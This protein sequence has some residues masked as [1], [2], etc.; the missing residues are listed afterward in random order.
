M[1]FLLPYLKKQEKSLFSSPNPAHFFRKINRHYS[2]DDTMAD[3]RANGGTRS[4]KPAQGI[5]P[6]LFISI[7]MQHFFIKDDMAIFL[8]F[9]V[10]PST[11]QR[12][13]S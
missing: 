13:V 8:F 3:G 1:A 12:S 5:V 10:V 11:A 4:L 6:G 2:S 7:H 9:P